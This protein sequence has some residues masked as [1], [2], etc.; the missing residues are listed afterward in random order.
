MDE[1]RSHT[2]QITTNHK[3]YLMLKGAK[4]KNTWLG[5]MLSKI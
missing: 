2:I 5:W 4:D 1:D 3:E